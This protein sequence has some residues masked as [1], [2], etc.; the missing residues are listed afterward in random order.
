MLLP[1]RVYTRNLPPYVLG[2]GSVVSGSPPPRN[3]GKA[4]STFS[5]GL[6]QSPPARRCVG[7]ASGPTSVTA[8]AVGASGRPGFTTASF[9]SS[10][11]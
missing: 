5:R 1:P 2:N 6:C 9:F 7:G 4:G 11:S 8:R 10:S 3:P